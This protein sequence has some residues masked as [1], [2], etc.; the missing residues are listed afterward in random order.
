[1][2]AAR[3]IIY[4]VNEGRFFLSHR[5]PLAQEAIA[6]GYDV[7]VVCGEGTGEEG[8]R[9]H[10]VRAHVI[11]F[12]R[13]GFNPVQ[14]LATLRAITAIYRRERPDIVHH[15]TIKPVLYG[16]R[17]ASAAG[18]N[19]VVNAVPGMGFVFTRRGFAASV[20]RA[21]V[22]LM[23][24]LFLEHPN[25]RV[26]FQNR[27]DM[28]GFVAHAIIDRSQGALIRGSGVDLDMF[29]ASAESTGPVTFLLVARMLWHKGVG[30][31]VEAARSLRP[32]YPDWR[33]VLVGDIDRGNPAS[34][35]RE[36]LERWQSEGL[37]EWLGHRADV[38]ALMSASHVVCLPSYREGLPKTLLEAAASARAMVASDAA[39]CRE[40]VHDGVTGLVVPVRD[41][42]A[43]ATAMERL[44][45]DP[46]LRVRFGRAARDKAEA[47]FSVRDVVVHTFR[48]YDELL[49]Q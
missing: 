19:A 14:E 12:S 40:V 27:E 1:V 38:A 39:G 34:L 21:F 31:F 9:A 5:L 28:R 47:V 29:R 46:A 6:R 26:I 24:R 49:R 3:R 37:I 33:F 36:H 20:R 18:V 11:P 32:R 35:A 16:T 17:A 30:E 7:Q 10:D 2:S 23:Y 13:S 43:L 4:V 25:M 41:V 48:V 42:A 44:G 45:R 22:N 15:V 8:L